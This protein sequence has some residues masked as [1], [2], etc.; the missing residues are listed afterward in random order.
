MVIELIKFEWFTDT[1][2]PQ[3]ITKRLENFV[4]YVLR[5]PF[6][7]VSAIPIIFIFSE[8]LEETEDDLSETIL[9]KNESP[10]T[11][12]SLG[13]SYGGHQPLAQSQFAL[14]TKSQKKSQIL[15]LKVSVY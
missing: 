11:H 10:A 6:N 7:Q 5:F 12:G 13:Y 1:N 9:L 15:I 2:R 14:H 8:K 4:Y 3:L